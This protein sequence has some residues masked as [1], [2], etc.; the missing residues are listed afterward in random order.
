M[1]GNQ[2]RVAQVNTVDIS[3]VLSRQAEIEEAINSSLK[4]TGTL[5]LV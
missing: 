5:T 3:D 1:N 4:S 2:V